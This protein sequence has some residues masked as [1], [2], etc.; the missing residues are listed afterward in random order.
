MQFEVPIISVHFPHP[1]PLVYP[2]SPYRKVHILNLLK[3]I[4]T[5]TTHH[6][7]AHAYGQ[8]HVHSIRR[9]CCAK[10]IWK[11]VL[12]LWSGC[13]AVQCSGATYLIS[14]SGFVEGVW[15]KHCSISLALSD[16]T[17]RRLCLSVSLSRGSYLALLDLCWTLAPQPSILGRSLN[18][19]K[20][21][22]HSRS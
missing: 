11:W 15:A 13:S 17:S 18:K 1:V 4:A 3:V 2:H 6:S 10:W 16:T 21:G 5:L 9:G 20:L 22:H 7:T 14:L 12:A 19:Y 8:V